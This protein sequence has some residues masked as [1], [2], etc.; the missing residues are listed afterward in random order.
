[1]KL[2]LKEDV[3]VIVLDVRMPDMDGFETAQFIRQHKRSKDTP[4]IF[5][6]GV[7]SEQEVLEGYSLGAVDY[8]LKPIPPK[9]LQAKVAV[10]VELYRKTQQVKRQA[11]LLVE[12]DRKRLAAELESRE[13]LARTNVE[14]ERANADLEQFAYVASHDLQEPLRTVAGFARLL[15]DSY[16]DR[17]DDEANGFIEFIVDGVARMEALIQGLLAYSRLKTEDKDPEP[18]D[19]ETVVGLVSTDL[20][21]AIDAAEAVVTHGRLPTVIGDPIQLTELFQ[22]LVSNAIKFR[23]LDPL[24]VHVSVSREDDEW[25]F[26]VQDN[27]I[28]ID[29]KDAERI[30]EIFQRLHPR[31]VYAGTGIG[32]AVCR[33]IVERHGGRVWVESEAGK[34]STFRFTLPA[35][36][37]SRNP[38]APDPAAAHEETDAAA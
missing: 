15:T 19:I 20:R 16:R 11:E 26:S 13:E 12:S 36:A 33:L 27:G 17:L 29:P 3:A 22:N 23:R 1:M 37:G 25:T 5:L 4:I 2:L 32:L 34:G 9:I 8:I 7:N 14:L 10:F 30:F 38:H 18:V 31:D 28:G 35:H 24:R 21:A 6:T